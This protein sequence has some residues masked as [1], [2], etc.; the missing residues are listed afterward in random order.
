M[1]YGIQAIA[2]LRRKIP[3][4]I[5]EQCYQWIEPSGEPVRFDNHSTAFPDLSSHLAPLGLKPPTSIR[6]TNSI[7]PPIE[8]HIIL[9]CGSSG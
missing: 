8:M 7:L 4:L 5:R 3:T 6:S 9:P 1:I 2:N